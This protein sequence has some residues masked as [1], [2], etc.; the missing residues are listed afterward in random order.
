MQNAFLGTG[1]SFPVK[2]SQNG[3]FHKSQ[4]ESSIEDSIHIILSTKIGERL[5]RPD[6]GCRIHELIFAPNDSNTQ[7]LAIFYVTEALAKWENRILL[8]DVDAIED[9]ENSL[10]IEI[11]YQVRDTNSFHNLVYPFYLTETM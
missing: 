6:F 3:T 7:N 11:K 2:V 5:M 1:V 8:K 4:L 10:I 9:S